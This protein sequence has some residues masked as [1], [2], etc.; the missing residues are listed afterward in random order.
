M[1][2][3]NNTA[4]VAQNCHVVQRTDITMG[5]L[6]WSIYDLGIICDLCCT[7]RNNIV[8]VKVGIDS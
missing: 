7:H 3:N 1:D 4:F 6:K 5:F 8:S 2:I